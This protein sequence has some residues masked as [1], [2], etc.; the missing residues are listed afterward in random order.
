MPVKIQVLCLCV[1]NGLPV[2]SCFNVASHRRKVTAM[3]LIDKWKV[4][5][6]DM[7]QQLFG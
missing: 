4:I 1:K 5:P 3:N 7:I 6:E 2:E